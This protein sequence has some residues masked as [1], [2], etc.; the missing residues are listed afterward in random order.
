MW[1]DEYGNVSDII[2]PRASKAVREEY[3][4]LLLCLQREPCDWYWV[5]QL[6]GYLEQPAQS[7]YI[8][9]IKARYVFINWI[10][11]KAVGKNNEK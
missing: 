5:V 1:S 2:K 7:S 4:F 10:R 9:K 11:G 6:I 3:E 8:T